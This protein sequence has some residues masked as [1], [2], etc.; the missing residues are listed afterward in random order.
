MKFDW[1]ELSF[2]G[3]PERIW[4]IIL[5]TITGLLVFSTYYYVSQ[6]IT[7]IFMHLYYYP[8]IIFAYRYQKKGVACSALLGIS[9]VLTVVY[10]YPS[11]LFEVTGAIERF[12]TFMGIALIIA[13]LSIHLERK[14]SEIKTLSQFQ[15]NIISNAQV[16]LTV[17]DTK[18]TILIWNKAAEDISGYSSKE[19]TGKN[20]IW[21]HLYPD[22]A[23]RKN[24]TSTI[25][26]IIDEN[27]YFEHFESQIRTKNG[28]LRVIS[29]NTRAIPNDA[30]PFQNFVVIGVDIT[31]RKRIGDAL[32][33]SE[34]RYS[35]LF[36]HNNSVSLLIDPDTGM[37]IDANSAACTWYGYTREQMTGLRIFDLN[38]LPAEKVLRNLSAAKN[39]GEK[40]FFSNHFL[41]SGERRNVEIFSGP[42]PVKGKPLFY[43]II[44]D[45]TDRKKA[46]EELR[47]AYE[48]LTAQDK[49]LRH[50]YD[51]LEKS[52][53]ALAESE[54]EYRNILRTAMDGFCIVDT[55]G[56]FCDVND[57]FCKMLGYTREEILSLSLRSIEV[58]ETPEDIAR[59]M[60]EIIRK[61]E[62]R[63]ES[64]YRCRDGRIINIEVSIVV[65]GTHDKHFITF[66][67]DITE[68]KMAEDA[69]N[70]ATQK[71]SL[72]N[73]ITFTDIQNAIYSLIG[74]L[75]LEKRIP[76]DE[77]LLQY[78]DKQ[79]GIVR[80]ILESLKFANKY[81]NLGIK[82]PAWQSVT[83][84]FLL[85]I[86]HLD[87]S[88]LSRKLDIEGLE[89][90][91]DPLLENVF[92]TLAENVV[93][94]GK[95]ATGIR[96]FYQKSAGGLTLVF[97]NN[98]T[99]IPED[100]KEKI[101]D[102]RY[103]GKKGLGLFLAREIL[104]ITGITIHE[105]G[106]PGKGARF[107]MTVPKGA[108]RM[109]EA[110]KTRK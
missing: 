66:H 87:I 3:V 2:S 110:D 99:G 84:T 27:K 69:L 91:A 58:I 53:H 10:F 76:M 64:R 44:H 38:H 31:E 101:F 14:Q 86:S 57:A 22:I 30:G 103:E 60:K 107:E 33:E 1:T 71:L 74:Y 90:Y 43:S 7:T 8:I 85:G 49:E 98:G 75:E 46:E 45:I 78:M 70:R 5:L 15:E 18:G 17:L 52:Q 77:K 56:S 67:R 50:Q 105:T 83:Q 109:T 89:I 68:R 93:L 81:Q 29:W 26:R 62:D 12:I 82:P 19:V 65:A 48:Q 94:H 41:A 73:Y 24:I 23:Y 40:H 9:Y 6:G 92:F 97:E 102:R 20:I 4:R 72:L 80:T 34:E 96:L 25:R 28:D 13:Y 39:A 100:M 37:I 11:N 51:E 36:Y 16:W 54:N 47:G 79:T 61:G 106:E 59:H 108:W 35:A 63:F 42:I 32:K 95:T 104:S 88:A 55:T 21:K